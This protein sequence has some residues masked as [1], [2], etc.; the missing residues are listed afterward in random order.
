MVKSLPSNARDA[1]LIPG[2][3][4]KII[5]AMGHTAGIMIFSDAPHPQKIHLSPN[6]STSEHDFTWK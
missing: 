5:Y 3:G 6:P 4:T 1:G 2:G